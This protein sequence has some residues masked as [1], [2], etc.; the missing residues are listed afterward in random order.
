[1]TGGGAADSRAIT[2]RSGC[3]I[4]TVGVTSMCS[5]CALNVSGMVF[6]TAGYFFRLA[7]QFSGF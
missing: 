1:M 6:Q 7:L 4:G 5:L 2:A 3:H